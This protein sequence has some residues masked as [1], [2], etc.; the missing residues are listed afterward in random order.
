MAHIAVHLQRTP[1]GLHPASAIALCWARDIASN[2]G[3]SVTGICRGDAGAND[4][5]L[6]EAAGR[7][8]ADTVLFCGPQGLENLRERL[9][10]VHVMVPYTA[11]GLGLV[12]QLPEGP[13]TARWID[14]R[15]PPYAT[16]DAVTAV[17]AGVLPW[18][19]FDADVEAEYEGNVDDIELPAWVREDGA[20]PPFQISGGHA[21]GFIAPSGT[22]PLVLSALEQL[23]ATET[24]W[25]NGPHR[26]GGTTVLLE[27]GAA[28]LPEGFDARSDGGRV[29][30]LPGPE[31]S[32]DAAVP[33]AW[34]HADW[35][36]PGVWADVLASV[37]KGPWAQ[38]SD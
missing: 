7:F 31:L 6:V 19:R 1:H 15:S 5:G 4:Q 24:T 9:N 2:R 22:D 20:P 38:A 11:E 37:R 13:P 12:E 36:L 28:A 27:P 30:M 33:A 29:L 14:R 17:V 21:C 25:A 32:P 35:V 8:G 16:A 34:A 3:A 10:P 23:G 26:E 18:H